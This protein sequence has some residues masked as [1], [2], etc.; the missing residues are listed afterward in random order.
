M[1]ETEK[2]KYI[3]DVLSVALDVV[4]HMLNS[5]KESLR[6]SEIGSQLGI[7]RT[8]VFRILKTLEQHR[9]CE[10]DPESQGY[11]LGLKFLE[12]SK[13]VRGGLAL[14]KVA[15]P[16]LMELA[17][18]TGDSAHLLVRYQNNAITIDRF[19]GYHR[20]QVA[21]PIG[22][23]IPLHVGATPKI[24]LAYLPDHE[25][26]LI[27]NKLEFKAFT[28]NTITDPNEL[29]NELVTIRQQGYAIDE[30]DYELGVIAIGAPIF[31]DSGQVI[32]GLA[33]TTPLI[34]F[35]P[36]Y[37]ELLIANVVEAARKISIRLGYDETISISN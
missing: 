8:R 29:R 31:D 17:Q 10:F 11:R 25:K 16:I 22:Q 4:E 3:I 35:S 32:A 26:E 27:I 30:E 33:I 37:C 1:I 12:F 14:R 2:D 13:H 15:E 19:Q 9:Y 28:P 20:L 23:P 7:N 18:S 21:T 5:D 24:L 34:R 6:P 36:E